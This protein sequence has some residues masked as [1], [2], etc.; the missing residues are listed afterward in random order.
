LSTRKHAKI[1]ADLSKS[2]YNMLSDH[3]SLL[4]EYLDRCCIHWDV[5]SDDSLSL[6]I[7][8][9]IHSSYK[10]YLTHEN[11]KNFTLID[12]DNRFL[13][14]YSKGLLLD[15]QIH[16]LI[17]K[18]LIF[19]ITEE[20]Q[21]W[22]PPSKKEKDDLSIF[23]GIFLRFYNPK[24][25]KNT[26]IVYTP[27]PLIDFTLSGINKIV[28]DRFG[29]EKGIKNDNF[30]FMIVDPAAGTMNFITRLLKSY[31]LQLR[32]LKN[33][34]L[35]IELNRFPFIIGNYEILRLMGKSD[36][37]IISKL[38][39]TLTYESFSLLDDFLTVEESTSI[40][41]LLGNPPYYINTQNNNS[42]IQSEIQEYKESLNE[43]NLKILSDDYVKFFKISQKLFQDNKRKGLIAYITN[44][45]YLDGSVF[46][47]MR[48]S[49]IRTFDEIYIVNLH[50][51]LRKNETGN[52]FNIKVGICVSFL[53]K[54]I[55]KHKST[56]NE[57]EIYYWDINYPQLSKKYLNL[58]KG[59]DF[60]HFV[61]LELTP[62]CFFTPQQYEMEEK[63]HQFRPINSLFKTEPKSGVM[64]GRDSLV[65]NPDIDILT[66]NL[67]LFYNRKFDE[68]EQHN[69]KIKKTKTWDPAQAL[70]HSSEY[71]STHS[72]IPYYYRGFVKDY[73]VY[74]KFLIDGA[75]L[76]YLDKINASN[77]A[78][79]VTRSIRTQKYSHVL[80]V[81][82]PPEKCLLG[83]R[84]SS[85]VFPLYQP[86]NLS[87]FNI[88]YPTGFE[89]LE[90]K[91]FFG[92]I[93]AILHA[94]TYRSR[95]L[96]QL[97]RNF[98]RIPFPLKK[99][100][101]IHEMG[102]LGSRLIDIHLGRLELSISEFPLENSSNLL[103]R[104]YQYDL[105][106]K[107]LCFD[108]QDD[109]LSISNISQEIWNFDI[110]GIKQLDYWL[111]SRRYKNNQK[112]RNKRHIGLTR[113]ITKDELNDFLRLVAK[114]RLTLEL[115]PKIDNLYKQIDVL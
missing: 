13:P 33:K 40:S 1:L 113:P 8:I 39:N 67:H 84:D 66:E 55:S 109:S 7:Q 72:I 60:S 10:F 26:G 51:N 11:L 28:T 80:V 34:I 41:I 64:T 24:M 83:I 74:D 52:P 37:G 75:R 82:A 78:I 9:I 89:Y 50:G 99:K 88:N 106:E 35:T 2:S 38:G 112:K 114:I 91:I 23:Y 105:S 108:I 59:F 81:D 6:F 17:I 107:K 68:M 85:Y 16:E 77:P 58:S 69:I 47:T 3:Y 36:S 15:D 54:T 14:E 110:G 98:P 32:I 21:R 18:F 79:C 46:K 101:Q 94:T 103:I 48:K 22:E 42:W 111:K 62:D 49:L 61:K 100:N 97:K 102:T 86:Q 25:A 92:Y 73:L 115:L 31:D 20:I 29:I 70:V 76:G 19:P 93:Y 71:Q 96:G 63:F 12:A 65:S 45:N 56:L 95:Y 30:P 104:D 27:P 90:P 44:N 57:A 43:K 53:V 5:E 4:K 87:Q